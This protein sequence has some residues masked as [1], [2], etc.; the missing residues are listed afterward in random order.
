MSRRLCIKNVT[1]CDSDFNGMW[2]GAYDD[3]G[4]VT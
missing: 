4:K 2:G 3:I 1:F